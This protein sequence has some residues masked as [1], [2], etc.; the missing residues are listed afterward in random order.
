MNFFDKSSERAK[1]FAENRH[2]SSIL[3]VMVDKDWESA[4]LRST[5]D[6]LMSSYRIRKRLRLLV[7]NSTLIQKGFREGLRFATQNV[8]NQKGKRTAK[9]AANRKDS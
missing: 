5:L 7:V 4:Q 3:S 6:R 9:V 2:V 8:I 1:K